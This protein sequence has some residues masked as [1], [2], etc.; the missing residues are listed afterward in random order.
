MV[1][2]LDG[3]GDKELKLK[4][5]NVSISVGVKAG[6]LSGGRSNKAGGGGEGGEEPEFVKP[7]RKKDGVLEDLKNIEMD[8]VCNDFVSRCDLVMWAGRA[9]VFGSEHSVRLTADKGWV[10][11]VREYFSGTCPVK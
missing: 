3:A 4:K 8:K 7:T 11:K 1:V 6:F 9:G 10:Q 5:E 2:L